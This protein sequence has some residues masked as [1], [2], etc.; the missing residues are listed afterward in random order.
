MAGFCGS[1]SFL[2]LGLLAR[3]AGA[4]RVVLSEG[5]G[6]LCCC[7]S[8]HEETCKLFTDELETSPNA[9]FEGEIMCPQ[10]SG[11]FD[12]SAF[13]FEDL[14][15]T[16]APRV[17]GEPKTVTIRAYW[18]RHG[19]SC[20]NA[21]KEQG[22]GRIRGNFVTKKMAK[23]ASYKFVGY[24]DPPLTDAG[25]SRAAVMG[26]RIR[27]KILSETGMEPPLLFASPMV[28]A[29]ETAYWNFP[30]WTIRP[31]PYTAEHG[32]GLDNYPLS[33]ADQEAKLKRAPNPSEI[34]DDIT[35]DVNPEDHP[36][37]SSENK[38][39]YEK[40]RKY[41]PGVLAELLRGQAT[42]P[43]TE[44]GEIPVVIVG[45]SGYM[46]EELQCSPDG[47]TKPRNNEVWIQKYKVRLG[48]KDAVLEPDGCEDFI[49]SD[50]YPKPPDMLCE[51][52]V[53]R[54][55]S[56]MKPTYWL[57]Q[58]ARDCKVQVAQGN[59]NINLRDKA[60]GAEYIQD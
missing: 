30:N 4:G 17:Q 14:P 10:Q 55:G 16:C 26:K 33:F 37:R 40:F 34:I 21:L 27:E 48:D 28:R 3:T 11:Y 12:Y 52:D 22:L 39:N 24:E 6:A 8:W 9:L 50:Y 15:G 38:H 2:L 19:W 36:D 35:F 46:L 47:E 42:I 57:D 13:Q 43:R 41:F 44:A 29:I 25:I 18:M 32:R 60:D 45:H 59:L 58:D 1:R 54:C 51:D 20:A 23:A 5:T 56:T 49:P 31:I 53:A 7:K